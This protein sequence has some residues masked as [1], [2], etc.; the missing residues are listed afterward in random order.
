MND[1]DIKLVQKVNSCLN[2]IIT[3][4][5]AEAQFQIVPIIRRIIEDIAVEDANMRGIYKKKF[6]TIKLFE[7]SLANKNF[8]SK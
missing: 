5:P 6:N 4:L 7:D 2:A 8:A 3:G 1:P